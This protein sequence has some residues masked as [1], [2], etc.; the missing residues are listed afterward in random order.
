MESIEITQADTVQETLSIAAR[1]TVTTAAAIRADLDEARLQSALSKAGRLRIL[2]RVLTT[3][4][5]GL[6]LLFALAVISGIVMM[7]YPN[8]IAEKVQMLI[9]QAF[10]S[11]RRCFLRE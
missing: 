11:Y 9:L 3:V 8:P 2:Q 5:G 4:G 7:A 10:P 1:E 6:G